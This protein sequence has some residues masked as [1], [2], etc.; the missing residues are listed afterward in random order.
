MKCYQTELYF[1]SKIEEKNEEEFVEIITLS[2][3]RG[4]AFPVTIAGDNCNAL[5][6]TSATRSC[7]SETFY[8]QLMLPWLL[9]AFCLVVT[10]APGSTLCPMGK[11]QCPFK[12]GGHSLEFSLIFLQN[13]TRPIILGLDFMCKHQIGLHWSDT[14]KGHLTLE[15]KVLVE[16]VNICETGPHLMTYSSLTLPPM[17]LAVISIHVDLKENS[18]QY[19]YKVK[20]NSFLMD[21]YPSMVIIPI[22][23]ITPLWTDTIIP[24]III[25][26]CI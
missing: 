17:T 11:V 2:L 24:F 3:T 4:P 21:Q 12:L 9:K 16:T 13:L 15:N 10:S 18:T 7:I 19:T 1:A 22:I 25:N 5:I 23:H 26:L 20:P 14:R 6:D 8:N